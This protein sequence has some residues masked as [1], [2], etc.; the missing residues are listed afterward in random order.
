M[1]NSSECPKKCLG[2]RHYSW[3]IEIYPKRSG[4]H[5]HDECLLELPMKDDCER[6]QYGLEALGS[7]LAKIG[8]PE[9]F[10]L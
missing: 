6:F 3:A 2:C 5:W 7:E 8:L 4:A 10:C 9:L 1:E